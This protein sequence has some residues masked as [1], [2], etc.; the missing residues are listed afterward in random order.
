MDERTYFIRYD[1]K[2]TIQ[3][4]K[5]HVNIY[6]TDEG[7]RV[8]LA[9]TAVGDSEA[10]ATAS[11]RHLVDLLT[12]EGIARKRLE[13]IDGVIKAH[14]EGITTLLE[15]E[16]DGISQ[17]LSSL[18]PHKGEGEMRLVNTRHS[19]KRA[20]DLA[21]LLDNFRRTVSRLQTERE[22]ILC[23]IGEGE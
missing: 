19:L 20:D 10:E 5:A 7:G 3:D 15:R 6:A 23:T 18:F 8:S 1:E 21:G 9:A 12:R 14:V 4:F 17:D 16:R 11:A 22:A 13:E 2:A